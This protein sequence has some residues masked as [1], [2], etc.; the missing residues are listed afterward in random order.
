MN[1][2][3]CGTKL[4]VGATVCPGCDT[5]TPYNVTAVQSDSSSQPGRQEQP[6]PKPRNKVG[7]IISIAALVLVLAGAG[8]GIFT[9][10]TGR[11][12]DATVQAT[13]IASTATASSDVKLKAIHDTPT[14]SN[15]DTG[16]EDVTPTVGET[17]GPSGLI[18]NPRVDGIIIDTLMSSAVDNDSLPTKPTTTFKV[19]Q[20]VY[21]TFRIDSEAPDGYV[22]GKWYTNDHLTFTSQSPVTMSGDD[23][24]YLSTQ[25]HS[26]GQGAVELYW[27]SQSNCSDARLAAVI[28]FTVTSS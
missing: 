13:S 8:I 9:Y 17:P 10:H 20:T 4:A 12:G 28:D 21:A 5:P 6:L 23:A 25:Y 15:V 16:T 27:C 22:K 11:Q 24:G 19:G 1:C 2:R 3:S 26:A 14:T 7:L 18:V